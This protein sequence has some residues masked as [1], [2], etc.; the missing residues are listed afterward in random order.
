MFIE[1]G[2]YESPNSGI[3]EGIFAYLSD[4][5]LGGENLYDEKLITKPIINKKGKECSQEAINYIC[6]LIS[7]LYFFW[8]IV[9]TLFFFN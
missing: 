8:I 1:G 6:K 3:S 4:I 5:Q 2:K 7:R 9:F